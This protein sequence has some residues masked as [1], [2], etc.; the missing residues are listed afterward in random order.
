[1]SIRSYNDVH[2]AVQAKGKYSRVPNCILKI[3]LEPSAKMLWIYLNSQASTYHPSLVKISQ[4]LKMG[5]STIIR[6]LKKLST[7]GMIDQTSQIFRGGKKNIYNITHPRLWDFQEAK[8]DYS[9]EVHSKTPSKKIIPTKPN[10]PND[11]KKMEV[12]YK[13]MN[14]TNYNT[15]KNRESSTNIP[16]PIKRGD[17]SKALGLVCLL[18]ESSPKPSYISKAAKELIAKKILDKMGGNGIDALED[19]EKY[20]DAFY[21]KYG[22]TGQV[23][24]KIIE[25]FC[26]D[27]AKNKAIEWW[28]ELKP[29][30]LVQ[31]FIPDEVEVPKIPENDGW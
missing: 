8:D 30:P 16:Q 22:R 29:Q 11:S 2:D 21:E 28:K 9:D 15:N 31:E 13:T 3:D 14:K 23:N 12:P 17:K 26:V 7:L 19:M 5:K 25:N 10:G 24:L 27:W 18:I 1:M 4:E 6:L 20:S